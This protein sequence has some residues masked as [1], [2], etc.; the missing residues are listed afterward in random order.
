MVGRFVG[1]RRWYHV[2]TLLLCGGA[3]K[4]AF[5]QK[6][7]AFR[8][9]LRDFFAAELTDEFRQIHQGEGGDI[10]V[11]KAFSKKLG[12]KGWIGLSWPK[13]Y[14][15]AGLGHVERAIYNEEMVL[16]QVPQI[17]QTAERQM[18]P[19]IIV[20][21]TETQ[22]NRYLPAIANGEVGFAIGYSEPES[23]SDLAGLQMRAS[24]DG[25][26]YVINGTKLWGGT[27]AMDFHWLAVR[28]DPDAPKH[29]GI[30]VFIV[31]LRNTPGITINPINAMADRGNLCE[32]VYDNVRVPKGNMIG[33]KDR[34]WYVT[35]GNLD[36]E[37]SG[38]ERVAVNYNSFRN[39]LAFAKDAKVNGSSLA[40]HPRVRHR[41]AELAIEFHIG[42]TLS[43]V[44][45]WKQGE[46]LDFNREAS[47]NKLFGTEV[48][49][50]IGRVGVEVLGLYGQLAPGSKGAPLNGDAEMAYLSAVSL[51]IAGG[52]SEIQ[53]NIIAQRGLGLPRDA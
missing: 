23:G 37:R 7:D 5:T 14:G 11:A 33:E 39:I 25:D 2:G 16:N 41:L 42:R 48:S 17:H 13:E 29:R 49:Q 36:F 35:T 10:A 46:G 8:Q 51:T 21:G 18:G 50:R 38:I 30:S 43:Y 22:K 19:S 1:S 20:Y 9:E 6:Q 53:R 26:D 12:Q 15:G 52:T 31:D 47:T 32:T 3:M 4:F 40:Y 34:G 44:V 45:A 24:E 27:Q 28:T